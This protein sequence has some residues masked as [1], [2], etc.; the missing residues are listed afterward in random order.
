MNFSNLDRI[1]GTFKEPREPRGKSALEGLDR[2][3]CAG[4]DNLALGSLDR[5][6]RDAPVPRRGSETEK[7][8]VVAS[9]IGGTAGYQGPDIEI[10]GPFGQK[11]AAEA[12]SELLSRQDLYTLKGQVDCC[13]QAGYSR[14]VACVYGN[15]RKSLYDDLRRFCARYWNVSVVVKGRIIPD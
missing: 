7:T 8:E 12:K 2:G 9:N 6:L 10:R 11:E 13:V 4:P 15:A 14:V 1:F 3:M 5:R